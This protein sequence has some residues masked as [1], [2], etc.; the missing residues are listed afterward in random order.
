MTRTGETVSNGIDTS[1]FFATVERLKER[2]ELGRFQFRATNHWI[3]GARN[4]S[5]IQGFYAEQQEDRSRLQPFVVEAAEP[6]VLFGDDSGPT[7]TEYLLHALAA[8]LTT[9]LVFV[10]ADRGIRLTD[11]ES[12]I[13]G[14]MDVRGALGISDEPRNGFEK[15]HVSFRVKGDAPTEEIREIVEVAQQRSAVFD[16]ITHGVPVSVELVED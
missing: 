2:P 14:D 7:P 5:V 6:A 11:V 10:A 15:I 3:D 4:R 9:T 8:C 13:D 16:I 1:K 12:T